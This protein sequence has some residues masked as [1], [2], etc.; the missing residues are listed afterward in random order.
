MIHNTLSNNDEE[1]NE[2]DSIEIQNNDSIEID[3]NPSQEDDQT[4]SDISSKKPVDDPYHDLSSDDLKQLI[5]EKE[6]ES[7]TYKDQLKIT[8]ADYQNLKRKIQSD[9]ENE[10]NNQFDKFILDYLQ[11]HD[12]FLRAKDAYSENGVDITGLESI[13]KNMN[14]FLSKYH[15]LPISTL[16]EIFDPKLHEA[17]SIHEDPNLDENTIT[18]ELRKGYISHDRVIRPALVEISK[19]SK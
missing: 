11:I 13:I 8:L 17:I 19:K 15:I 3:D 16:G 18:K 4:E 14:S 7:E 6:K 9:I 10:V 1:I 5:L 12:D 2:D